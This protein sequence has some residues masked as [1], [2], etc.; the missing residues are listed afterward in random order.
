VARSRRPGDFNPRQVPIPA[1]DRLLGAIDEA[2]RHRCG[3]L[4]LRDLVQEPP[5]PALVVAAGS[6]G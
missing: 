6:D 2:R 1:V 5:R 3:E 4:T